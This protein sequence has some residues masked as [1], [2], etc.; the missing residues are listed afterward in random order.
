MKVLITGGTGLLGTEISKV[1]L[2]KKHE[3]VFLSRKPS[4]NSLGIKE[5]HWNPETETCDIAA[6][7]KV[8]AIINLAGNPVNARWTPE[9]K[10]TILRS[11]VDSLRLIF[12]IISLHNFPVKHII[13][14]SGVGYYE[15]CFDKE[16]TEED[17]PGT[18]FLSTVCEKWEDEVHRFNLLDINTIIFRVG[19][20]LSDKGGALKEMI[21]PFKFGLGSPLAS[22]RQWIPWIHI[23]DL[24]KMFVFALEENISGIYNAA[25]PLNET[26]ASLSR[27]L[28][29]VLNK[30]FFAPNVPAVLLKLLM[31]E[32][33]FIALS[34]TRVSSELIQS[35]GFQFQFHNLE[36][37]LKDLLRPS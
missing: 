15:S 8:E 27:T 22:G 35:K 34:S 12:K 32:A 7:K 25:A 37:A 4:H 16:Y 18:S 31:G 14:A 3:V 19:V 9:Y 6:F 33:A 30:P 5:Y 10:S 28:A 17:K 36:D 26:N 11:R 1:L 29:N 13:S 2:S 23:N 20:V 24:A 21:K